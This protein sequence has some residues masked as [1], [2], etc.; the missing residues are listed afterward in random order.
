MK[1]G[2]LESQA[3]Q[4]I[5]RTEDAFKKKNSFEMTR[6]DHN[7]IRKFMYIMYYRKPSLGK[8]YW[9][10]DDPDNAPLN[11]WIAGFCER[12]NIKPDALSMWLHTLQYFLD[13]PHPDII[14]HGREA[15][16]EHL[17]QQLKSPHRIFKGID[18]G[19]EH[20]Q[21]VEYALEAD[22]S[23]LAIWAA[24]P[25][26]E[27]ILSDTSFGVFEGRDRFG[28]PIHSFYIISPQIAFVLCSIG[29]KPGF[30]DDP[31][32]I[33]DCRS[34]MLWGA[35]HKPPRVTHAKPLPKFG[36]SK[37]K[38][39]FMAQENHWVNDLMEFE[40]S[41][42]S[43]EHTHIVNALILGNVSDNG[44]I[45]FF[46]QE[47]ILRTLDS[48]GENDNFNNHSKYV[49]LV[50]MLLETLGG[51]HSF[52]TS[53]FDSEEELRSKFMYFKATGQEN[54]EEQNV[55]PFV[56]NRKDSTNPLAACFPSQ[57]SEILGSSRQDD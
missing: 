3:G 48:F 10:K 33:E 29:L 18:P 23:F 24:A 46:S 15:E 35:T 42:L 39:K 40:I 20:Y 30:D 5:S 41:T 50:G 16:G 21:A 34:S 31:E 47:A 19:L 38:S 11:A 7:Y 13:T 45:T 37:E 49:P 44:N 32:L 14:E 4:V 9:K 27:F 12:E 26:E 1:L 54:S 17:F 51:S 25:G 55:F 56:I 28:G 43:I 2:R 22:R 36:S 57:E 6:R 8:T 53:R 52:T